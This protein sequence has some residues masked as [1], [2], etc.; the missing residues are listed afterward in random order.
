[1]AK[2][3]NILFILLDDYGWTDTGC[4]GST[5]Y[6]TPRLD[7]LAQE[8]ARFTDAYASCPVCSPTRAS[9][10][11]GKYPA[12]LG[13]TQWLGGRSEGKLADVPYIDHLSTD[14]FSLANALKA[15]GYR[16]WHVGKWH[17]S[18]H[19]ERRFETYPDKHGFDVN[20]GGCDWGHPF[21][22]YFSPYGIETLE[23]G[24]EGEYLTDR[25]TDEAIKL[26]NEGQNSDQP[27]FMYLSHYAV[28]TPIECY[29]ELVEKYRKKARSLGLD[30]INPFEKG[31]HFPCIHKQDDYVLRRTV[32]SDPTYAAM[33][34]NL[35]WNIGRVLDCLKE[36]GLEED[37]IVIFYSDNGGL[38]TAEGSPTTNKPLCEG[39]G[40]MYEG[41]TREPLII[42]W[43]GKIAPNIL[44]ETPVTSTD[45]Y[46]TLLEAAGLPLRP[47][48]HCDGVS[49]LPIL[50]QEQ[51][52]LDRALYWHY[53]HYSNQGCTPGCS[54]RDGEWKLLEFFEDG[55]LELYH[56]HH[57]IGEKHDLSA[58]HPD[59][60]NKLKAK[61]DKWKVD[62]GARIPQPNPKY[63]GA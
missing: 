33:V 8:G 16:T 45:F 29:A 24:P 9:I 18:K 34:E 49:I 63:T 32:Q 43:K 52:A 56:I 26:I 30:Q 31:E 42:R 7:Q 48:Q 37:T 54:I 36:N 35:D 5:F 21:K 61:L 13:M 59:I 40:W 46:P 27:W 53:P 50:T 22:G 6:E 58:K 23:D 28:H 57:D 1:M 39:K 60:V 38:A 44:L 51:T 3:P 11:T 20:I 19:D 41:G 55:R 25:L 2:K 14:E 62:V 12:R 4:Y 47:E 15:G 10:L 17:L